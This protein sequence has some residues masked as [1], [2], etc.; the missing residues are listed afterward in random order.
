M[1]AVLA[2]GP[3]AVL[4]HRAAAALHGLREDNRARI[5]V[6]LPSKSVYQR[7]GIQ[8]HAA[9]ALTP[10]DITVIDGI[11]CTT[12]SRTFTDLAE[13]VG[14][15]AVVL[16]MDAAER[17]RIFDLRELD[18]ALDRAEGRPGAAV[19]RSIL[20]EY[21]GP[22]ERAPFAE[23]FLALCRRVELPEPETEALLVLEDGPIHVDFLWREARIAV[24]LDSRRF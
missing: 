4:S 12:L 21:H 5:D 17:H 11:P 9:A 18:A 15:R 14:R 6:S 19:I 24:E 22:R 1:A 8:A 7:R 10:T 16:G 13:V 2:Y 23:A 3:K 20:D